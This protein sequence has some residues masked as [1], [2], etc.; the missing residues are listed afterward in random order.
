ML[1]AKWNRGVFWCE[2]LEFLLQVGDSLIQFRKATFIVVDQIVKKLTGFWRWLRIDLSR[3][4]RLP[5][6]HT[7]SFGTTRDTL[8]HDGLKEINPLPSNHPDQ[9]V[10]GDSPDLYSLFPRLLPVDSSVHC[11]ID[12]FAQIK[13]LTRH[14]RSKATKRNDLTRP[15]TMNA[16]IAI[17]SVETKLD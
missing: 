13:R 2:L 15:A 16:G 11:V 3:N 17:V 6:G 10:N 5:L 14:E 1:G 4:V 8:G 9:P 7:T 12:G